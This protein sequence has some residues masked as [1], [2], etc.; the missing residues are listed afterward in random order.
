MKEKILDFTNE[1]VDMFSQ[2][3]F[4]TGVSVVT[5]VGAVGAAIWGTQQAIKKKQTTGAT[6][7]K[8][9]AEVAPYYIPCIGLEALSIYTN[10]S[11]VKIAESK[12]IEFAAM[13]AITS[14]EYRKYKESHEKAIEEFLGPKKRE[15]YE[16]AAVKELARRECIDL[17]RDKIWDTG[18]GHTIFKDIYTDQFF[19]SSISA[20]RS[21]KANL[22][23]KLMREMVIDM[24]DYCDEL[25]IPR[26]PSGIG[27]YAVFSTEFCGLEFPLKPIYSEITVVG[28]GEDSVCFLQFSEPPRERRE[29]KIF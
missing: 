15:E 8:L 23:S 28:N 2:P 10:V 29:Y 25:N 18:E 20:V 11:G 26:L 13:Y 3:K 24:D 4:L 12:A 16:A 1:V 5:S 6:G 9:V 22:S 21:H 19:Y 7:I 17:N 14:N 27:K